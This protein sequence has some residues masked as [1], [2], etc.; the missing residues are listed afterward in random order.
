MSNQS[1]QVCVQGLGFV[2]LAM[3]TVLANSTKNGHPLFQVT[4]VDLPS[5]KDLLDR[6]NRGELPFDTE[7]MTFQ[8]SLKKAVLEYKNLV[9]THDSS[10]YEKADVVIVDIHLDIDKVDKD[11]YSR[12][13]LKKDGF[14]SAIRTLGQRIKPECLVIVETTV[15]PGFCE[16][17][18]YPILLEEFAKRSITSTPLLGHSY[19]RVMPGKDYLHSIHSFFRTYS[20]IDEKSKQQTRQFLEK[21]INIEK[22]PLWE[23]GSPSASE[24]AKVMEN[25]YRAMNIA[26]IQEWTI[27]A[28]KMGV[29]LFHVID[30]IRHRPTHKNIMKPGPGVGGYCLTKDSLLA[31]WSADNLF[32]GAVSLEY[33]KAALKTNDLMPLHML[34]LIQNRTSVQGKKVL[35][36]GVS[37]REDVGD[38]RF[39]PTELLANEVIVAGGEIRAYDPYVTEWPECPQ[40]KL[41][42]D[43]NEAS[44][45]EADVIVFISRH[46]Q[47]LE[48]DADRL[49]KLCPPKCLVV[50][51]FDILSDKKITD[52]LKNGREVIGVGKGHIERMKKGFL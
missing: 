12:F 29:D 39:S 15:P 8:P 38:T 48:L 37:Y 28:E 24:L 4:G 31:Q 30:G 17:V 13:H 25:S 23:E 44:S 36:M 35:L 41:Y 11:N 9:A 6:I 52:L 32:D 2:G 20:G 33:S 10:V 3:A 43:F 27:L 21:F 5:R 46:K 50:D 47:L 42:Q 49:L 22:F 34:S 14:V 7:D 1:I 51:G 19:E 45:Y 26:F 16:K 40:I 18:V